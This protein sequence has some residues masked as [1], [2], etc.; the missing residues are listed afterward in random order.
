M[1]KITQLPFSA[2]CC[3]FLRVLIDKKMTLP[4][5]AID[6]LVMYF[7]RFTRTHDKE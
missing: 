5:Q 3:V 4:Y 6:A 1:V 2:V 7:Y